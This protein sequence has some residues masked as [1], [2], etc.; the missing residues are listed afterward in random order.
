MFDSMDASEAC[1][2]MFSYGVN[3]D[4][5]NIIHEA[6]KEIVINVK[7]PQGLSEEYTLTSRIM[8]GDTWSS[9]MASAQVLLWQGDAG[10]RAHLHVQIQGGGTNPHPRAS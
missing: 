3:D 6:N 1:G 9:A 7:T 4:H 2:D 5:L 10:R 8:Q